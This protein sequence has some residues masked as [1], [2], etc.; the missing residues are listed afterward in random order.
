PQSREK[1]GG[2]ASFFSC[3]AGQ[4]SYESDKLRR[5]L[6]FHFLIEGLKGQAADPKGQVTLESLAAYVKREMVD[7]QIK[8]LVG[9][10][11]VQT[12]HLVSDVRGNV[13]LADGLKPPAATETSGAGAAKWVAELGDGAVRELRRVPRG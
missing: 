3:S 5:G 2:V 1:P 8:G 11:K 7:D 13:A 6:F 12:P 9:R 4:F 10:D